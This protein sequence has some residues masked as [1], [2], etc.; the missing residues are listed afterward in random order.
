MDSV[1]IVTAKDK[2]N[3][4]AKARIIGVGDSMKAARM[5]ITKYN[6]Y[7]FVY[8]TTMKYSIAKWNVTN[9]TYGMS[10]LKEE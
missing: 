10:S 5:L 4:F 2:S 9:S 1:Y 6:Q 3:P 7:E 8:S